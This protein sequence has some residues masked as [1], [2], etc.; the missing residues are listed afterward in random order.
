SLQR[1]VYQLILS[2]LYDGVLPEK[3]SYKHEEMFLT[4]VRKYENR[5]IH[6]P[7][8]MIAERADD[9][10]HAYFPMRNEK[11]LE[12]QLLAQVPATLYL[13]DGTILKCTTISAEEVPDKRHHPYT[14]IGS[15]PAICFPLTIRSISA[16]DRMPYGGLSGTKKVQRIFIAE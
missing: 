1:K 9:R 8:G 2:Y 14:Y 3:L 6:F 4:L 13:Q 11:E 12:T 7:R 15:E 16:G 10:L 5:L